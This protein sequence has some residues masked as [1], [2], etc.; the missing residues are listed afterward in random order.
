MALPVVTIAGATANNSLSF[1]KRQMKLATGSLAT[2]INRSA[3]NPNISQGVTTPGA[4]VLGAAVL[5]TAAL[6]ADTVFA[7]TLSLLISIAGV[8]TLGS[9]SHLLQFQ[10]TKHGGPGQ[11][12][13]NL[14]NTPMGGGNGN[15]AAAGNLTLLGGGG[16]TEV[17]P[18]NS[19]PA[20]SFPGA[21][22]AM[23]TVFGAAMPA[24]VLIFNQ[25]QPAL[26]QPNSMVVG[27]VPNLLLGQS[28]GNPGITLEFGGA[29]KPGGAQGS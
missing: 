2:Q 18:A 22:Q 6:G 13:G 14:P 20:D 23:A 29:H 16:Y 8:D 12:A 24:D 27:A 26:N 10:N 17:T 9:A 21:A 11:R 19:N 15:A 4:A 3:V 7:G 28:F 5:G 1:S 25:I